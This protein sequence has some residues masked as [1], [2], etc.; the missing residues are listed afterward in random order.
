MR[1]AY[2]AGASVRELVVSWGLSHGTV[3]NRLHSVGT[4]MCTGAESRRMRAERSTGGERRRQ[5]A[6]TLRAHYEAL[7]SVDELA[8]EFGRSARTVR[9]LLQEAGTTMRT[10]QETR[11]LRAVK[12][13]AEGR[14]SAAVRLV[15]E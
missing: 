2:D 5:L 9:R 12:N 10:A 1:T 6:S 4:V 13:V 14:R 3:I 15:A 11:R 7:A 8:E